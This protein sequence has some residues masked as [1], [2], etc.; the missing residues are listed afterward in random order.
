M[1]AVIAFMESLAAS[2]R[3]YMVADK[4]RESLDARGGHMATSQLKKARVALQIVIGCACDV[5]RGADHKGRLLTKF[6]R[7]RV[8]HH[9]RRYL[10][11]VWKATEQQLNNLLEMIHFTID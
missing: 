7:V 3:S 10:P 8:F 5:R 4:S 9:Q 2:P 6:P 1:Q 11:S